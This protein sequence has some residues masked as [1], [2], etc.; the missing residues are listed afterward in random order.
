[1]DNILRQGETKTTT[2]KLYMAGGKKFIE[3]Q[4]I[5]KKAKT[6]TEKV[7]GP[8]EEKTITYQLVKLEGEKSADYKKRELHLKK[9][10]KDNE[11][12]L[13]GKLPKDF[14]VDEIETTKKYMGIISKKIKAQINVEDGAPIKYPLY[15]D[16][17]PYQID[18]I[19]NNLIK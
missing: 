1:M 11:G 3:V 16:P 9:L 2:W 17:L 10:I 6:Y 5:K 12:K 18:E 7:R 8:I 15:F 4:P 13:P 14:E 19:I